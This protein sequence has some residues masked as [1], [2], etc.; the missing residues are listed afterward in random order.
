MNILSWN[1]LQNDANPEQFSK[2]GL[3]LGQGMPVVH[4]GR[5][6]QKRFA[7]LLFASVSVGKEL[8]NG[9]KTNRA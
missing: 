7:E 4:P 5:Q 9:K 2:E 6:G 8:Q 3:G 1:K